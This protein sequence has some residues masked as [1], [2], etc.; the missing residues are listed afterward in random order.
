[1]AN[2]DGTTITGTVTNANERGFQLHGRAEW[3][4]WSK[5]APEPRTLPAPGHSITAMLD[6]QG[7]VRRV[8]IGTGRAAAQ[9][10]GRTATTLP[11]AA[12]AA[13]AAPV[14]PAAQTAAHTATSTREQ[15]RRFLLACLETALESQQWLQTTLHG[16]TEAMTLAETIAA[17]AEGREA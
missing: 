14:R 4:N 10:V 11:A 5:Y 13:L 9:A 7:W 3:Y 15:D 16:M 1:M 6:D 8:V 2:E 12:A 17:W